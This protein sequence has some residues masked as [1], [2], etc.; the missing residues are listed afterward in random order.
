MTGRTTEG[1]PFDPEG[2]RPS[3]E[4]LYASYGNLVYA[5]AMRTLGDHQLAED[6]TQETWVSAARS[7]DRG[8]VPKFPI[9]W[10]LKIS[11]RTAARKLRNDGLLV[12]EWSPDI[13]RMELDR[14][15]WSE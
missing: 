9:A 2:R 11:R 13:L 1:V 4:E 10:L 6:A 12:Y 14:Y 8:T 5:T 7:L 3:F 15:V